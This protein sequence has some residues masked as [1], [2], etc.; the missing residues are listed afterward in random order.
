LRVHRSTTY[1]L[2]V[3]RLGFDID[4][5]PEFFCCARYA[6][7]CS[8]LE[9][10]RKCDV[11]AS[12]LYFSSIFV[13][14]LFV[15][16]FSFCMRLPLLCSRLQFLRALT[17][18]LLIYSASV[19]A[20]LQSVHFLNFCVRIRL[21][22]LFLRFLRAPTSN[23]FVSSALSVPTFNLFISLVSACVVLQSVRFFVCD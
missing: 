3:R 19:C 13:P 21:I 5:S 17:S 23:L 7:V 22:C 2:L 1:S 12:V 4:C 9:Y 11:T 14:L 18:H 6:S 16:L 8:C 15:R 20:Y 10:L